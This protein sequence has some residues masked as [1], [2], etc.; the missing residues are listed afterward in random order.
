MAQSPEAQATE[1]IVGASFKKAV[2]TKL[3]VPT[4]CV[5]RLQ[6]KLTQFW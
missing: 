2:F 3:Y 5:A 1:D 4:E 6:S